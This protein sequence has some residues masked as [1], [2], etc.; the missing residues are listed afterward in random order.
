MDAAEQHAPL[1]RRMARGAAVSVLGAV[2]TRL[3][4]AAAVVVLARQLDTGEFAVFAFGTAFA[5]FFSTIADLGLDTV[6]IRELAARPDDRGET[7]GSAIAAKAM[8]VLVAASL[9]AGVALLYDGQLQTAGLVGAAAVLQGIPGT[10]GVVLTADVQLTAPTAIRTGALVASSAAAVAIALAGAGAITVLVVQAAIGSMSGFV[11]LAVARR[12]APLTLRVARRRIRALLREAAPVA[13]ATVAVVLFARVD[14][15][16]LGALGEERDLAA[17]GVIVRVVDVLNFVPIAIITVVLPAVA[18]LKAADEA[19][20]R[21]LTMRGNRYLACVALPAAAVATAVGGPVLDLVFGG[22]YADDG[23]VLAVL[24]WAHAF[25]FAFLMSRQVL[26]G[27]DRATELA[28]L[29][30]VAAAVNV[31]LNILLIPPHGALGAA[32]ASLVAYSSPMLVVGLQ[33]H[34]SHPFFLAG[35]AMLRPMA[36]AIATFAVAFFVD[37]FAPVPAV[38][39]VAACTVPVALAATG[40]ISVGEVRELVGAARSGAGAQ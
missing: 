2:V 37:L 29:S 9:G 26:I 25:A 23:L 27:L 20:V 39:A 34:R 38:L 8:T 5:T 6:T 13:F 40:A 7:L 33:G 24:L 19:R 36:A 22:A 10:Y 14:Q 30:W 3:T 1:N 12:R 11:L 32:I 17:Y 15:L 4:S 35:R 18:S 21:R 16:L 28:R 31:V